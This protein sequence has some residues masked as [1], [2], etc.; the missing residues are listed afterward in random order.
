MSKTIEHDY[1]NPMDYG[2]RIYVKIKASSSSKQWTIHRYIW[3]AKWTSINYTHDTCFFSS[4]PPP[5]SVALN[6]LYSFHRFL[7]SPTVCITHTLSVF[8]F[9]PPSVFFIK[10]SPKFLLRSTS[11]PHCLQ[12]FGALIFNS[13]I[14]MERDSSGSEK[15]LWTDENNDKKSFQKDK[16]SLKIWYA[17]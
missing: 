14:K 7:F 5:I 6:A 9:S 11:K 2:N 15:T 3:L 8:F 4:L 10:R 12:Y 16:G 13:S 17:V 1:V